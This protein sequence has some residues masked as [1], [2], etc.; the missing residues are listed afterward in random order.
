MSSRIEQRKS[1]FKKAIDSEEARQKRRETESTIR[2]GKREESLLKKRREAIAEV[3]TDATSQEPEVV[4]KEGDLASYVTALNSNNEEHVYQGAHRI[5][6][7]LSVERNPPIDKVIETGC[8]DRFVRLLSCQNTNIQFECA[9]AL[10]NIASGTSEQ[11]Q[12]V[13]KSGAIPPFCE[14]LRSPSDEVRDQAVWALGN[15]AGDGP[16]CRNFLLS[17]GVLPA[18]MSVFVPNAPVTMLRN[19]TWALSNLCRGKPAPDFEQVRIALPLVYTLLMSNDIEIL[20]DAC[21]T[22]SYLSDGPNHKIQ[23][24]IDAAIIPQLVNLMKHSSPKVHIP[25]LR[26]VGNVVTGDEKHTQFVLNCQPLPV[27]GE[28]LNSSNKGIRKEACWAIS[29]ITAGSDSQIQAVLDANLAPKL[30]ALMEKGDFDVRREACWAIGNAISGGTNGQ[31]A[32]MVQRGCIKPMC[33]LLG[34]SDAKVIHLVLGS[35]ESIL[36]AGE[37]TTKYGDSHNRYAAFVEEAGATEKIE[38]LQHH[39][40]KD[41]YEKAV[42]LLEK[43]LGGEEEDEENSTP[44]SMNVS[45]QQT[46]I[47]SYMF[48]N[49]TQRTQNNVFSF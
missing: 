19:A 40:N 33:D 6:K 37:T 22:A 27:L 29:N 49:N 26:A 4:I 12:L 39:E 30:I 34:A 46:K 3:I 44:S 25:A 11:T 5:R 47:T 21:W 13:V 14:L 17:C 48:A 18:L 38:E 35:L 1:T 45:G 16:E 31:I 43:Y 9:W 23:A 8:V 10:T 32:H 36:K 20:V 28:L 41:I 15:I 2:K 7:L 42:N 24:V